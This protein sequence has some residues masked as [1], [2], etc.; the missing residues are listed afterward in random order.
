[1]IFSKSFSYIQ[2]SPWYYE[3]LNPL[4]DEIDTHSKLLDIGTGTGKLLE[5]VHQKKRIQCTG[6]DTNS[7][8][9]K[10]A[11]RKLA[12]TNIVLQKIEAG[13]NFPF[14]NES[15]DTITICNVLFNLKQEAIDHILNESI[16]L[17][18]NNGKIIVLTPTGNNSFMTLSKSYFSLKNLS[19]YIWYYATRNR[20]GPWTKK[21]QLLKFAK[22]HNF[23]YKRYT[24]LKDFAQVEIIQT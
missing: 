13:R 14:E 3:F 9:L 20:A 24:I 21:Q 7:A 15:F 23:K 11:K 2:D 1:M 22:H 5:L 8:M 12:N 16:R 10:E 19:I 4:T 18:K 17:L 6:V